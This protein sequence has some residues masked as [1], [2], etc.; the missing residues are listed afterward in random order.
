MD[1]N[2][3]LRLDAPAGWCRRVLL[4]VA[5]P[6]ALV[7]TTAAIAHAAID[8]TWIGDGKPVLSSKLAENLNGLDVRLSALDTRVVATEAKPVVRS[9]RITN[10]GTCAIATQS[11]TWISSVSHPGLGRCA[12][13][14]TA[15][16]WATPP[17]CIA[18]EAGITS[19]VAITD[20]AETTLGVTVGL[21]DTNSQAYAADTDF[22]IICVSSQ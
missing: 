18:M 9:A 3:R 10:N 11:G 14:F 16:S 6:F 19:D 13:V 8:T 22:K 5:T 21:K 17:T 20:V 15:G 4:Y 1:I 12:L 2:I 7:A